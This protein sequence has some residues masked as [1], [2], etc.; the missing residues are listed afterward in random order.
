[1]IHSLAGGEVKDIR[2]CDFAKVQILEGVHSGDIFWYITDVAD[3]KAQDKVIVP[4]GA[5]NIETLAVVLRVDK[6]VSAYSSPV[7]VKRAKRVV[8]KV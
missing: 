7:P 4:L 3:L 5:N 1:M 6:C 8:R 2:Y